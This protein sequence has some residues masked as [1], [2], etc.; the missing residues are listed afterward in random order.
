MLLND[1]QKTV[2]RIYGGGDYAHFADAGE[3]TDSELDLC[4]DTLFEFLMIELS[5]TE[6]CESLEEAIRRVRSARD[7][8]DE[9]F[10]ALEAL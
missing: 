2:A 8:L 7:Q 6:D 3:I 1:W 9:T 10:G 4:G 5:D